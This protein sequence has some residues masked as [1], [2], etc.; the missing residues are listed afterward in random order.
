MIV[1]LVQLIYKWFDL[2]FFGYHHKGKRTVFPIGLKDQAVFSST[3]LIVLEYPRTWN[4]VFPYPT[5]RRFRFSDVTLHSRGLYSG[6]FLVNIVQE[7]RV[8]DSFYIFR[9]DILANKLPHV[10]R[11]NLKY[12][13]FPRMYLLGVFVMQFIYLA[14]IYFV[15][16]SRR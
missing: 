16:N 2:V 7:R 8:V 1:K 13:W 11:G 5:I 10:I 9:F 3:S 15:M 14:L 4:V 6:Y 12:Q